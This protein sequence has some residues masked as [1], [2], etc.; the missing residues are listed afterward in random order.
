MK[1]FY[2]IQP[3]K[4]CC[5]RLKLLKDFQTTLKKYYKKTLGP[6]YYKH[7]DEQHPMYIYL[8]SG[9]KGDIKCPHLHIIIEKFDEKDVGRF[10]FHTYRTMKK[11]YPSIT[12]DVQDLP[13]EQDEINVHLYSEKQSENLFT[14]KDL[15]KTITSVILKCSL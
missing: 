1:L 4:N 9:N 3:H 6:R 13:T 5:S 7:K 14:H 2:T 11:I 12:I 15:W 8:S 10:H